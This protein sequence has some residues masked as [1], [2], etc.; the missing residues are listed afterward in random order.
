MDMSDMYRYD[1][2]ECKP[3]FGDSRTFQDWSAIK[4]LEHLEQCTKINMSLWV[5]PCALNSP[6]CPEVTSHWKMSL[7]EPHDTN[8]LLSSAILAA[9]NPPGVFQGEQLISRW[10][11]QEN[12]EEL[13]FMLSP[14]SRHH[15]LLD[16]GSQQTSWCVSRCVGSRVGPT[17]PAQRSKYDTTTITS[18]WHNW[19]PSSVHW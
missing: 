18:S 6:T 13:W 10:V 7:S 16:Y 8:L 14:E 17:C 3:W 1:M 15:W 4:R 12:I 9:V 19:D 11:D 2:S 5:S